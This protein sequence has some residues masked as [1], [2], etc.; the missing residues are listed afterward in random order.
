MIQLIALFHAAYRELNARKLFWISLII[1]G[2][3]VGAFAIVGLN[4]KGLTILWWEF[5]I[6]GFNST[7]LPPSVFYKQMFT[8]LGVGFWLSWLATILALVSTSSIIPDM[9]SGGSI[10][11]MLSKP[12]S[13]T[14]LFLIRYVTALLFVTIQ[15]SVFTVASFMVIGFRGG[16]WE[17]WVLIAIPLVVVFFSY[18]Y[19]V[20]A[21]VGVLTRSTIASLLITVLFWL[22]IFGVGS[23]EGITLLGKTSSQ[24]ALEYAQEDFEVAFEQG[25]P[26]MMSPAETQLAEAQSNNETWVTAHTW[27]YWAKVTLPKTDETIGL[28]ERFLRQYAGMESFGGPDDNETR[29][30]FGGGGTRINV[31]ELGDRMQE[32]IDARSIWWVIGTSLLF[33]VF[34]LSIACWLFSRRDF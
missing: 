17:P 9:V 11:I 6:P 15:V 34:V 14:R 27:F 31:R 8:A 22:L 32:V 7:I 28:L 1:S 21:L 24:M 26:T 10:D 3:L 12:I 30:V 20:C 13:R 25:D 4:E 33:E 2:L 23:A 19:C 18:L 5:Q 29:R 16:V